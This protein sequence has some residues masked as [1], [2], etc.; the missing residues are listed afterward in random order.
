M[1]PYLP[2]RARDFPEY[3]ADVYL[4][5]YVWRKAQLANLLLGLTDFVNIDNIR[6]WFSKA[7]LWWI[8]EDACTLI[9]DAHTSM[10][11]ATLT[12]EFLPTECGLVF[13]QKTYFG[14]DSRTDEQARVDMILWYPTRMR[15]LGG[16]SSISMISFGDLDGDLVA[17]GRSDWP[18]GFETDT[19][20]AGGTEK[21]NASIAEDRRLIAA[22]WQLSSQTNITESSTV[23][24]DRHAQKRLQR[25]E[26]PVADVRLIDLRPRLRSTSAASEGASGRSYSHQ[27]IVRKHW[28]QVAYG[29]GKSLRRPRLIMPYIAGPEDKPLVVKDTVK[30]WRGQ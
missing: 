26:S 29:P 15:Q 4:S 17:L 11:P 16:E 23:R 13:W 19:P 21:S 10:P 14:I 12:D 27:W 7:Q 18:Y 30:V 3:R 8:G 25:A 9:H 5:P 1:R 24:P 2:R 20:I 6:D 28:R 22:L